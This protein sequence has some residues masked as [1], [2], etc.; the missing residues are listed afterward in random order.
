MEVFW[1]GRKSSWATWSSSTAGDTLRR[2]FPSF[3]HDYQSYL[4]LNAHPVSVSFN[5]T[6]LKAWVYH[7]Q[8][9]PG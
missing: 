4:M 8:T 9:L 6:M 3:K 5:N 7:H 2:E 1:R